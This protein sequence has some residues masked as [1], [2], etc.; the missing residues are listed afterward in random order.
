VLLASG[1]LPRGAPIEE[2]VFIGEL[3]LDGTLRGVRGTLAV[4]AAAR[5]EGRGPVWLPRV[6]AA[7][8]RAVPA[9]VR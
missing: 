9:R 6:N 7:E 8:A 2:G 3:A 1:Q 5:R 4:L